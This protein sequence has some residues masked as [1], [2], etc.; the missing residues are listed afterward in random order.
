MR[1]ITLPHGQRGGQTMQSAEARLAGEQMGVEVE[2]RGTLAANLVVIDDR[3]A[4]DCTFPPLGPG[5]RGG[6]LR[7]IES[8]LTPRLLRRLL[9]APGSGAISEEVAAFLPF[10]GVGTYRESAAALPWDRAQL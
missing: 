5:I 9:S 8:D 1:L 3:V 7:R 2:E 6:A 4:W 10:T